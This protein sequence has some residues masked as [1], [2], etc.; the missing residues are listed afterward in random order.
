MRHMQEK[1]IEKHKKSLDHYE[2]GY[3][4]TLIFLNYH[5]AQIAIASHQNDELH[6]NRTSTYANVF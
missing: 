6:P 1:H 4:N 3:P 2:L 5:S